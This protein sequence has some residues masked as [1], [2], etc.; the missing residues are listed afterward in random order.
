MEV[1]KGWGNE[2]R[3]KSNEVSGVSNKEDLE[4]IFSSNYLTNIVK[5]L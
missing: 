4:D 5:H 3:N 1:R 2:E